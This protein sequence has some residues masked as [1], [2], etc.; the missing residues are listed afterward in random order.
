MIEDKKMFGKYDR[1]GAE[2]KSLERVSD[3]AETTT[4]ISGQPLPI[5]GDTRVTGIAKLRPS[6]S[7]AKLRH[8][9]SPKT[10]IVGRNTEEDLEDVEED[11]EEKEKDA[12]EEKMMKK[13]RLIS[14]LTS[15]G[16]LNTTCSKDTTKKQEHSNIKPRLYAGDDR[17]DTVHRIGSSI[18]G[19]GGRVMKPK[20]GTPSKLNFKKKLELFENRAS[21]FAT[22]G[23]VELQS[24][25]SEGI[26]KDYNLLA[27][28]GGG[29]TVQNSDIC[30]SQWQGGTQIRPRG[31]GKMAD[32]D[33]LGL[34]EIGL[35][36]PYQPTRCS[37]T[38]LDWEEGGA[39]GN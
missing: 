13:K 19:G 4:L 35:P 25:L 14:K 17:H 22:E 31:D 34:V 2:R 10:T 33:G 23:L 39:A 16:H 29:G 38:T 20:R 5:S 11:R 27:E 12:E 8:R 30:D 32:W 3:A 21:L 26:K 18:L 9:W 36:G 28:G 7:V 37:G 24:Q 6:V 15:L 1:D